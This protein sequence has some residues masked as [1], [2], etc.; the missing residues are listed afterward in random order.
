MG[1]EPTVG[2]LA[3]GLEVD[4]DELYKTMSIAM[5]H[6][7]LDAP[8]VPGEDNKLLD[9][10]PDD[11]RPGPEQEAFEIQVKVKVAED[12]P[13]LQ[14][15]ARPEIEIVYHRHYREYDTYFEFPTA[16]QGRLRYREDQCV[17]PDGETE[18]ARYRLT[19]TGPMRER[20]Y[21]GAVLLSRSRFIAGATRSLRFYRE[22]FQPVR[23]IEVA[24]D[25]LRW[26]IR[27]RDTEFFINFD[28]LTKPALP[29][30][31]LEVKARTW[32]RRD[33]ENKAG[34]IVEIIRLL[35]AEKAE[36]SREEYVVMAGKKK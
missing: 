33:A 25:R 6:L 27:Y 9:Y 31:F 4:A 23:E 1:R 15:L 17:G 32:S 2:E 5:A 13:L 36:V 19:L 34:M 16:D 11:I 7:S 12:F 20:E 30:R 28:H 3:E 24:K 10:L 8:L 21:T 35:G 18:N 29:G 22:Y 26:K 14:Q